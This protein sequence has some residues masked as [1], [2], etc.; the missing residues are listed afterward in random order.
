MEEFDSLQQS[1]NQQAVATPPPFEALLN[2]AEKNTKALKAKHRWT[3]FIL[4][5]LVVLL[6][7]FFGYSTG[8]SLSRG[9]AG[10]L[11]MILSILLR[12]LLEIT[13]Y[14]AFNKIPVSK[15]FTDYT[16]QVTRFYARRKKIH[17]LF[18]PVILLLYITGFILL[19][20]AFRANVSAGFYTYIRVSG[21][22]FFIVFGW[23]IFRQI[24][25]E[26]LLLDF[27][28]NIR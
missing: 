5:T 18:T 23:M 27:L 19:L 10:F 20:P 28:K 9:S 15:S 25:K 12:I 6:T 11:F 21:G 4:S 1:W 8:F 2:S 17:Y 26:M 22:L 7:W 14:R 16:A 13:S 24:K 3:T